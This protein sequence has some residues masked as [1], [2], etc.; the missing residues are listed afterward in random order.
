M[1]PF[2]FLRENFSC[3]FFHHVCSHVLQNLY[4]TFFCGRILWNVSV[5]L[6]Y[7]RSQWG[8][9][10]YQRPSKYILLYFV[11]GKS[12]RFRIT[13]KN[14][15][16]LFFFT[17]TFLSVEFWTD[18]HLV[19]FTSTFLE[20]YSSKSFFSNLVKSIS[21]KFW[22]NEIFDAITVRYD[23]NPNLFLSLFLPPPLSLCVRLV[24]SFLLINKTGLV[25]W[26][27]VSDF[28]FAHVRCVCT[29]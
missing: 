18:L 27:W 28:G 14:W 10:F 9:V 21:L 13:C 26:N 8:P 12:Y 1:S 22:F 23:E 20:C 11:E 24:F 2:F 29:L 19:S 6:S 7:S 16:I 15:I 25:E 5:V 17:M 3:S 4:D